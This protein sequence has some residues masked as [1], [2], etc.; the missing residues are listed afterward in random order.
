L[1]GWSHVTYGPVTSGGGEIVFAFGKGKI[2]V[3]RACYQE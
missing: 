2:F 1:V 3:S